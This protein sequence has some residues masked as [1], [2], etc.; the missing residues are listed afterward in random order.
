MSDLLSRS[1]LLQLVSTSRYGKGVQKSP[2]GLLPYLNA[3]LASYVRQCAA[4]AVNTVHVAPAYSAMSSLQ[5]QHGKRYLPCSVAQDLFGLL[6][7]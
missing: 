6:T 1:G 2:T 3:V 7:E 5:A 4:V